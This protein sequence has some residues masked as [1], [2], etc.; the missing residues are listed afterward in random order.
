LLFSVS[1][2]GKSGNSSSAV[3]TLWYLLQL[4]YGNLRLK[5]LEKIQCSSV[6]WVLL[7]GN[8]NK[9]DLFKRGI[10]S[11][12]A[13]APTVACF[14]RTAL[15]LS[16]STSITRRSWP[17]G[18]PGWQETGPNGSYF[19]LLPDLRDLRSF[20]AGDLPRI[21]YRPCGW[22]SAWPKSEATLNSLP[23]SLWAVRRW[24]SVDISIFW[25]S[26]DGPP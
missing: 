25:L 5:E 4:M 11:A 15:S 26:V 20:L 16:S 13:S 23:I 21:S 17:L 9:R 22:L 8:G 24:A 19:Q 10:V 12:R 14:L 2:R 3:W 7:F 6:Q 18:S 1:R